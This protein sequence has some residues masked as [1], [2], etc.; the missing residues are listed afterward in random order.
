MWK[1]YTGFIKFIQVYATV[2][3]I[4]LFFVS[5]KFMLTYRNIL[6]PRTLLNS[7]TNNASNF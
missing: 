7:F 5:K 3:G 2:S 4:I 6:C 1:S